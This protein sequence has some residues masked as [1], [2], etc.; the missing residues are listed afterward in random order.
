MSTYVQPAVFIGH[1]SP[2]NVIQ[3]NPYT[4][5]LHNYGQELLKNPPKAIVVISAHWLTKG[6]FVT[7]GERPE[8]I[9]DFW[10]FPHELYQVQYR[11]DGDPG[12]AREIATRLD[13]KT[14][15]SR[16][17]DHAAWAVLHHLFPD[18]GI[19]VLEISLDM[20]LSFKEHVELGRRLTPLREQGVL[21]IGSGNLVHN[22]REISFNENDAPYQWALNIDDWIKQ[23]INHRDTQAMIDILDIYPPAHRAIPTSDHYVPFLYILGMMNEGDSLNTL[24]ESIQ[25]ASISMRSIEVL[26]T[27]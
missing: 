23:K 1:G 11:V 5:F 20:T 14:N 6:T 21:F 27:S 4:D 26:H 3:S 7:A 17:I 10:G 19:P 16:G 15:D 18:A 9:Y 25:N 24:H 2:M 22:L 13:A 12:L 8:Q